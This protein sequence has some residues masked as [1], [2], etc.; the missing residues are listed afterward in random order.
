M[1]GWSAENMNVDLAAYTAPA[2]VANSAE[3]VE[4]ASNR[5]PVEEDTPLASVKE[6]DV[7]QDQ[8]ERSSGR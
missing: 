1:T 8:K 7:G 2:P 3:G 4:P 6:T 5:E